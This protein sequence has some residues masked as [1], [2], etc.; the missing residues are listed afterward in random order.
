M[1]LEREKKLASSAHRN[2][3]V[4]SVL[5]VVLLGLLAIAPARSYFR[6]WR[7]IQQD[8][9]SE[10]LKNGMSEMPVKIRQIWRPEI[11]LT[12]RCVSCHVASGDFKPIPNGGPLFGAHP[13]V[14]HD[15][16]KMGCTICHS[17]QGLATEKVAAHGTI[18]HWDE[19]MLPTHLLEASCGQ[20]HGDA[21]AVPSA[22]VA[23]EGA[24]LFDLHGCQACH[25]VDG[26]GGTVGPDLSGVALK[27]FS[28]EWHILHLRTPAAAVEGSRMMNF[29]HLSD[30]HINKILAYLDTLM[31]AP[32]LVRGKT[33][34]MANGCRGCHQIG[35]YGGDHGVSLTAS[36]NTY[37]VDRDFSRVEG[38]KTNENWQVTHLRDPQS[39]TPSSKMPAFKLDPQDEEALMTFIFSEQRRELRLEEL[40]KATLMVRMSEARDYDRSDG[41]GLFQ[42]FCSAC[43]GDNALGKVMPSL[44]T[45]VPAVANPDV[46]SVASD[47]FLRMAITHG[48]PGRDMPGWLSPTGL[49]KEEI[50]T[51]V[52]W[53]RS[54]EVTPPTL[55][56][57]RAAA[58]D[59][60]ADDGKALFGANCS[61]CH[62]SAGQGTLMAPSLINAEFRAVASDDFVY[63]TIVNGRANTGMPSHKLFTD[64]EVASLI[65]F[66]LHEGVMDA[67]TVNG[68]TVSTK[69]E[70]DRLLAERLFVDK[71]ANYTATGSA[72]Y[73]KVLYEG[74]CQGCHGIDALGGIAPALASPEFLEAA[75]DGFIAGSL[76]LGRGQRAMQ[77]FDTAG[78]ERLSARDIG[79]LITYLREAS[80]LEHDSLGRAQVQGD[81]RIGKIRFG[82]L[83]SGC[84]GVEGVGGLAP[85]LN[86]KAFLR[87]A[88]DG[89]LQAT[90]ARGRRGT[91]MRA[92]AASGFGFAELTPL[93][94]NDIVAYIRSWQ[95]GETE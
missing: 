75:S 15:V 41:A 20:C 13:E 10:A 14:H 91:A 62:G 23:S 85:A 55:E 52:A 56:A 79:D 80:K 66:I 42:M 36:A 24:Y 82:E 50:S 34:A 47:E 60:S 57:V 58:S 95:S 38:P 11:G 7:T 87:A 92:W 63:H 69:E 37:A 68:K 59:A 65:A 4:L 70:I 16:S 64:V 32:K 9:N 21:L 39:I 88:T 19:P 76:L 31:G 33:L 6:P 27:G 81:I 46:L 71:L 8:Y 89:F 5:T 83:C 12:D 74:M 26:V 35:G 40:P 84:H 49:S 22:E 94:I 51:L 48:R 73:G 30:D 25:V 45:T 90:I 17:G 18:K 44:G 1:S 78:L 72:V 29:G 77:S 28:R 3:V 86:N 53:I 61:G 43:H 54:H 93:E 67:V 2:M